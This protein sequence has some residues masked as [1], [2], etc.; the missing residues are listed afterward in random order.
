MER[1]IVEDLHER[2]LAALEQRLRQALLDDDHDALTALVSPALFM[3][4]GQGGRMLDLPWLGDWLAGNLRVSSLQSYA[5]ETLLCGRLALLSSD[6]R[7]SVRGQ[8]QERELKLRLL[9]VWTC[10]SGDSGAQLLSMAV[11]A[12]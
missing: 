5:V 4:D 9:R 8:G 2:Q 7:L 10:S 12:A 11:L 3:M 1:D 6:V